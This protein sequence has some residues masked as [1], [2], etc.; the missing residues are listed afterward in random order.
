MPLWKFR[1]FEEAEAHLDER[2]TSPEASLGTALFLLS[3]SEAARRG[4]APPNGAWC[5]IGT[6]RRVKQIDGASRSNRCGGPLPRA[7]RGRTL[8][9]TAAVRSWLGR[10]PRPGVARLS[11][12]SCPAYP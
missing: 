12:G 6:W 9:E 5:A 2:P 4:T 8:K 11:E 10:G 3:I 7:P 1:T